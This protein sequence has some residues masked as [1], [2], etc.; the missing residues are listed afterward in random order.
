[1]LNVLAS[2]M[3]S[4]LTVL[5]LAIG[6]GAIL[7]VLTLGNAGKTQVE[8]E[9]TRLGIDKVWLSAAGEEPL[10]LGDAESVAAALGTPVT[11]QAYAALPVRA[12]ERTEEAGVVGCDRAYLALMGARV[13]AGRAPLPLEW[14]E[15]ARVALVGEKLARRLGK[16]RLSLGG[17]LFD[18]VGTVTLENQMA[19]FDG[20]EAVYLPVEVFCELLGPAVNELTVGVPDSAEPRDTA[21]SAI[22]ALAAATGR[23]AKAVTMQAQI[24]AANAVVALFV[25]VLKW[26]AGI[27]VLVGG[28]GVMNILL[29]SVRERR[30]EIGVMK[31]LG[32]SGMQICGLFLLEAALYAAAGGVAGLLVGA[33]I[34]RAAAD[35]IGL[36]PVVSARDALIVL[37][38]AAAVGLF[39]GAAPAWR[40]AALSPVDAL[41]E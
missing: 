26:V 12:G 1:M 14:R 39:F 38:A 19:Q 29:V 13:I 18:A 32:A 21:R 2:P 15:G 34:I 25:D 6:V 22:R 23:E 31:S 4:L 8:Y 35:A 27:C 37:A 33:G 3:R 24:D 41:R 40:A 16:G 30:R 7:A 9:M 36:R 17:L 11:E 28:I 20:G 5:G 10:R